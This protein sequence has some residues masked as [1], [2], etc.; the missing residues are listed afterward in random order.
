MRHTGKICA[1]LFFVRKQ[2]KQKQIGGWEKNK[3][4]NLKTFVESKMWHAVC[5]SHENKYLHAKRTLPHPSRQC[6]R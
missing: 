6:Q 3:N 5:K 2:K 1:L 4:P